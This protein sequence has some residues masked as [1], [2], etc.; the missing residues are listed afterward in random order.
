[1][2][3][4]STQRDVSSK[5][6]HG[7]QLKKEID[8]LSYEVMKLK[9]EKGKELDEIQRLRELQSYKERENSD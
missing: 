2:E 6:D 4:T 3:I 9:E 8:N 5:Q 7:Y 1:M